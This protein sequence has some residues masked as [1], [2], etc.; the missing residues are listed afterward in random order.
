MLRNNYFKYFLVICLGFIINMS[1]CFADS[2]IVQINGSGVNLRK[3]PGTNY[4]TIKTLA[5]GSIYSL[6]SAATYPSERSCSDGWYSVIYDDAGNVGYVCATYAKMS[7]QSEYVDKYNRPWTSPKAAIVGGAK[8]VTEKYIADGQYTSYLKK[9]NVDPISSHF[10]YNHIYM[11]NLQAPYSEAYSSFKSYQANGLLNLPLEFTIPIY[12][13][14]PEYTALPGKSPDLSCETSTDPIFEAALVEQ[15]FPESYKCKLRI[16][17]KTYPNWTFKALNT[18]LDFKASVTAEKAISSI[19]GGEKYYDLSTGQPQQTE[20]GWYKPNDATVEYY[21]DPR[22]FLVPERILMFERLGYSDNYT[23]SVVQTILNNT[24]MEGYSLLDN[25]LYA[26]IFVEAGKV[27]NISAV[28]LASLAKQESGNNG[29]VATKGGEFT[30]QGKTYSGL[31]NFL[32]IG[33]VSSAE[34]PVLAGLVWASGGASNVIIKDPNNNATTEEKTI[35]EKL[36][37]SKVNGC[38]TGIKLGSAISD[39]QAALGLTVT[40]NGV[41]GDSIL[42]TGQV[43]NISDG[44]NTYTYTVAIKGDV[45]G[46]GALGATDYVK[47]KNYI[48]EKSGSALSIAQSLAADVDGNGSIGAT[49]YVKIKNSIME[50]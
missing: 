34:S 27:A 1:F 11:A 8:Y 49:D 47:I 28:Y 26:S 22:N 15:G 9:F 32:N 31:Y 35:L 21:L 41:S 42:K 16:I 13:G 45:D 33:A 3:G 14:M 44:T 10:P 36:G 50:R 18:T 23:E 20:P 29:S 30:Y 5:N 4:G 6:T 17:H 43:I 12:G 37:A 38:L 7:L 46:D 40:V 2:Y 19:Q 48:M 24:F 39:I 25:Q